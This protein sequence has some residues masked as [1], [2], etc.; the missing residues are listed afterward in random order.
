[1]KYN[2]DI[3]LGARKVSRLFGMVEGYKPQE[4][5]MQDMI[6]AGFVMDNLMLEKK[7]ETED[8]TK[9]EEN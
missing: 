1:M 7:E 6:C 4:P 2:Y 5:I 8:N 9:K 3:P